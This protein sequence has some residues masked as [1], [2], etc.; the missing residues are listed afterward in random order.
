M[1]WRNIKVHLCRFEFV[2]PK[3][4]FRGVAVDRGKPTSIKRHRGDVMMRIPQP[5]ETT[6]AQINIGGG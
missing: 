4:H 1:E 5:I 2:A 3:L 6:R